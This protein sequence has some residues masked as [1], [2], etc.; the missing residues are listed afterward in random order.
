MTQTTQAGIRVRVVTVPKPA[1]PTDT[2]T[3]DTQDSPRSD[4]N[5]DSPGVDDTLIDQYRKQMEANPP[6]SAISLASTPNYRETLL[7][8]YGKRPNPG[9][10]STD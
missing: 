7:Q 2:D 3:T 9:R 1:N 8:V 10:T 4:S 5:E 6:P